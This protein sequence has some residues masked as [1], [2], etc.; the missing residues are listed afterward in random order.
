MANTSNIAANLSISSKEMRAQRLKRLRKTTG[1]SRKDFSSKYNISPGTL[2]NWETAR[3]GG[4]TEK[5]ANLMISALKCEQVFCSFEWLMYQSGSS[6]NFE[7]IEHIPQEPLNTDSYSS[8][9]DDL[10]VF[11][12]SNPNAI[13]IKLCDDSMTPHFSAGQL[14]AGV[15]KSSRHLANFCGH[16]CIL[17]IVDMKALLLRII[18]PHNMITNQC[19]L[20]YT[21]PL[22]ASISQLNQPYKIEYFAPVE[23][24]RQL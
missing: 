1:L 16:A 18:K 7:R 13:Y 11:Q 22:A 17:K 19:Y 23:W 3:F 10:M 21:N 14:V 15:K 2:Q 8:A 9:Q 4:L 12:K 5:G 20:I 24:I 6:P